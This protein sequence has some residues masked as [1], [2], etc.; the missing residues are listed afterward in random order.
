MSNINLRW[1]NFDELLEFQ[2]AC[3]DFHASFPFTTV[4]RAGTM[5][6]KLFRLALL[7][8]RLVLRTALRQGNLDFVLV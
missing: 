6:H 3:C 2:L 4:I 1:G 7:W 8:P 5:L